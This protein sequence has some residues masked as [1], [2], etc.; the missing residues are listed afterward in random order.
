MEG[1]M[2]RAGHGLILGKF[3]PPHAGHQHLVEFALNFVERLTVLVCSL[4]REPIAGRLRYRWMRELFPQARIVHVTQDLPQE[5]GEHPRFWDIWRHIVREAAGAPIDFVFA[6]EDYGHRL[7]HELGAR[8]IPVDPGREMVTVTGTAIRA[9]PLEHWRFLPECVRPYFVK[10]VCLF[11]PE[12]TGKSTMARDLARRFDTRYVAEFARSLLDSKQGVCHASDIP[13]IARGQAA[14]EDAL[15]R[16]ANKILFCDTDLLLTTIWSEVL[17]GDCPAWIRA[18][19]RQR[20]YDLYLLLDVDVPWVD[21]QRHLP[22]R[23]REFFER[24]RKALESHCRPFVII[25]GDWSERLEQACRHA[26]HLLS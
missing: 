17:F 9:R 18:A 24:C 19:A 6:S 16:Q 7:A 22:H 23:R 20:R 13:L 5:P 21:D 8:F 2:E 4:D 1:R 25:R 14:A 12:S 15:A 26:Q 10:R 11:G 3:M